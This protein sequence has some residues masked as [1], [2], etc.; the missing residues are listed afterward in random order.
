MALVVVAAVVLLIAAKASSRHAARA[1]EVGRP[2]FGAAAPPPVQAP[3]RV[4]PGLEEMKRGVDSHRGQ[5]RETLQ[6]VQA[7]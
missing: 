3:L 4:L 2:S 5:L 6:Q 7:D 1:I